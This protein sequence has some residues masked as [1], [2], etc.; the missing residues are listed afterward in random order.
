MKNMVR[1]YS[2]VLITLFSAC[3]KDSLKPD[4]ITMQVADHQQDCVGVGPQKCLLVKID[5]EANWTYFYSGIEGFTYKSGFEYK[6][7]VK[8]E[9]IK[10]PPQD[11]SSL[12]YTLVRVIEKIKT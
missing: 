12:R 9:Q 1:L 8:R 4:F 2:L 6:L 7:S 5:G 3:S 11:G 10:N